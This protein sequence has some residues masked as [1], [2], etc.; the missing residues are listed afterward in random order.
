[1][2]GYWIGFSLPI[3]VYQLHIDIQTFI[4]VE[5]PAVLLNTRNGKIESEFHYYVQPN[6]SPILSDFC[7][8]LTG[9]QQVLYCTFLF[10]LYQLILRFWRCHLIRPVCLY[11]IFRNK[12]K[13]VYRWIYAWWNFHS[14]YRSLPLR[15][16]WSSEIQ[17]TK[18]KTNAQ[19]W[20]GQVWKLF[21]WRISY[22]KTL[23]IV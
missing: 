18:T 3:R 17:W 4:P 19:L 12:L 15:K 8:E 9:I 6:E 2:L 10:G 13:T 11:V 21:G 14:G 7:K 23:I 16:I 22:N 1:M 20:R 5:F